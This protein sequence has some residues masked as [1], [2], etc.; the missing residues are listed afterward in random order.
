MLDKEWKRL[1]LGALEDIE[2]QQAVRFHLRQI[3]EAEELPARQSAAGAYS[4]FRRST[5]AWARSRLATAMMEELH[6][7]PTLHV[8]K[9]V[10]RRTFGMAVANDVLNHHFAMHGRDSTEKFMENARKILAAHL[11]QVARY[12][13]LYAWFCKVEHRTARK[14]RKSL[15]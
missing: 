1:F 3:R 11:G 10:M 4:G 2:H 7:T 5:R 8:A 15:D 13:A 12:G 6:I 9:F 14:I